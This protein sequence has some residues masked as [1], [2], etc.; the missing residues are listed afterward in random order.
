MDDD[1]RNGDHQ[2]A[3]PGRGEG[4]TKTVAHLPWA[5]DPA[6]GGWR[7]TGGEAR[8]RPNSW[9]YLPGTRVLRCP[10][11]FYD[12]DV[13]RIGDVE[14][15]L[16]CILRLAEKRWTQQNNVLCDAVRSLTDIFGNAVKRSGRTQGCMA[17]L[18]EFEATLGASA[19]DHL[20]PRPGPR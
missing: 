18:D 4:S 16:A 7:Y 12:I 13:D 9:V 6:A 11:T 8:T 14:E 19:V 5:H 2:A 17:D 1:R 3:P 10:E 20:R 15:L